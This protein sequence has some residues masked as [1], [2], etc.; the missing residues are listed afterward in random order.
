[1]LSELATLFS[2]DLAR[3]RNVFVAADDPREAISG[4]QFLQPQTLST[5]MARFRPQ[6]ATADQRGLA[7]IWA[8]QYFMRLFPPVI[9]AALLLDQRMPLR[10]EQLAIIV[11]GEGLP[12]VF[13]LPG[14]CEPLPPPQNPFERFAHL[15][16]DNLQP[17][18]QALCAH[19]GVSAKVLWSNAGNYFE[20]WLGQLQKRSDQPQLLLDGQRLLSAT[21]RPDGSRN[22]L[23]API[24]YIDIE[25]ADGQVRPWRQ[26]RLCCIRYVLPEVELCPNCPRLKQPQ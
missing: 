23:Y 21:Q 5:L 12:L 13:K 17:F 20:A 11:D 19:T 25:H 14:P 2:G 4:A 1:M 26:R 22:P 8:N 10:I 9:S 15:L 18:I 6:F 7:S 24:R 3:Y 16:D